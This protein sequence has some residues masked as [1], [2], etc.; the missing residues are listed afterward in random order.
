[1]I[2]DEFT[3]EGLAVA[4]GR[5]FKAKGVL[6]VLRELFILRGTPGN[7]RSDHGRELIACAIRGFLDQ[8]RMGTLYIEPGA[9][10]QNAYA[11]SIHGRLRDELLGAELFADLAE[12]RSLAPY[13]K[14][15]CNHRRP[16]PSLGYQPPARF[17]A[18][19]GSPEP[20]RRAAQ[21][22][23]PITPRLSLGL[24]H[25]SQAGQGCWRYRCQP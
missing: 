17:A 1:V 10:W 12:A 19:L 11:E 13:W 2:E 18:S 22:C 15:D 23:N 4:V 21:R 20:Q 8:A 16:H 7:I 6:D 5:S 14:N 25:S 9:S 24:A 3:R